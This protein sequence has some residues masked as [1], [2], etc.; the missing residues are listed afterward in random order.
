MKNILK[1]V[2]FSGMA[3]FAFNSQAETT[4]CRE[5]F[6]YTELWRS[7]TITTGYCNDLVNIGG[8]MLS[9]TLD[10]GLGS[11]HIRVE[12]LFRSVVKAGDGN[13]DI[14][15]ATT[16]YDSEIVSG[17]G[18]DSVTIGG[19]ATRLTLDTGDNDDNIVVNGDVYEGNLQTG[20]GNDV[21]E[22]GGIDFVRGYI[23][24]GN[25]YDTLV[26]RSP[27]LDY[28]IEYTDGHY[29]LGNVYQ[30]HAYNV[31]AVVFG[32]GIILVD[33]VE[34]EPIAP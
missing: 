21:L 24:M 28:I 23:D 8:I 2:T 25:G 34:I 15:V 29:I 30:T 6:A 22:V 11:D 26:L 12:R 33:G 20:Y 4:D 14:F 19:D 5:N 31:E 9:S 27:R 3:M 17:R 10:T 32:D 16:V 7:G 18:Q 13:N 1:V